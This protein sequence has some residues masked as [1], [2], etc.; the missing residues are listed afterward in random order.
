LETGKGSGLQT[1][2]KVLAVLRLF[3]PEAPEWAA[4]E[5]AREVGMSLPTA[6]R[7]MRGLEARGLLVRAGSRRYRLGF[8][9]VE[10]GLRALKT[11]EVREVLRPVVLRLARDSDETCVLAAISEYRDVAR[12]LDR[13]EGRQPVRISLEIGHTWPLH[14]GALGKA[15]LAHMPDRDAILDQPL[16]K[17][18]KHTV[19]DRKLLEE[20]LETI[21]KVGWA[22]SSEET[23]IGAWGVAG[24]VLDD[25]GLPICSIGLIAPLDRRSRRAQDRL[26]A[27]LA[28]GIAAARER[29][30]LRPSSESHGVD[31]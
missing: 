9:A 6:S 14:A 29:F 24:A 30:G 15:L 26:V 10:L 7:L 23:E 25:H 21:R 4:A 13:A 18:G 27:L 28:E 2:D 5:V 12:V 16:T 8:A 20:Q 17:I 19:T 11:L 22:F 1:L 31:R 3:R